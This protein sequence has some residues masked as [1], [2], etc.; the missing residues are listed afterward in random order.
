MRVAIVSLVVFYVGFVWCLR[1]WVVCYFHCEVLC[2]DFF[3]RLLVWC[4]CI[5]VCELLRLLVCDCANC[6]T[7]LG[8]YLVGLLVD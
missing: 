5:Y 8:G 1:S 3:Y 6:G 4:W 7:G 2:I